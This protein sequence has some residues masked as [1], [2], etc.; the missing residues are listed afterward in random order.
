MLLEEYDLSFPFAKNVSF[1]FEWRQLADPFLEGAKTW[2]SNRDFR[3]GRQMKEEGLEAKYPVVLIPGIVSTVSV[4]PYVMPRLSLMAA[5]SGSGVLVDV[6]GIP[7]VLPETA[8]GHDDDDQ[9]GGD[10]A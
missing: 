7:A 10:G 6:P 3:V 4:M 9:G 5:G 1:A 8:M 2:T